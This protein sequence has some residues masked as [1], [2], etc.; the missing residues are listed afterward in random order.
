M[1][2]EKLVLVGNLG[3]DPELRSAN[4]KPVTS[5]SVAVNKKI[6][7]QKSTTWWRCTVWNANAEAAAQYLKK[8]EVNRTT[9]HQWNR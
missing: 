3:E 8:N 4:G 1:A 7:G 6:G 2:Y 9:D 5:F